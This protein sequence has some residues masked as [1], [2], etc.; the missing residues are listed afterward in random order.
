MV[1]VKP[2]YIDKFILECEKNHRSSVMEPGNCRFD[3]LQ[4]AEDPTNFLLYEAYDS[5]ESAAAHKKTAHYEV[6]R[7]AV[8]PWMAE[9]RRGVQYNALYPKGKQVHFI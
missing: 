7:A 8:A 5:A 4:S 9:P 1:Q 2:E 3:I 6:W